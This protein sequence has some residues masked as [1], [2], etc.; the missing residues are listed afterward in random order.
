L[1]GVIEVKKGPDHSGAP[2]VLPPRLPL[3]GGDGNSM[4]FVLSSIV[5]AF[6]VHK[7]GFYMLAAI[8]S[9]ILWGIPTLFL[10]VVAARVR[11]DV[12][13]AICRFLSSIL[14]IGLAGVLAGGMARLTDADGRGGRA[15]IS[16]AFGFCASRFVPLFVG[17]ALF[18]IVIVVANVVTNGFVFLLNRGGT[19]GSF[20]A[21]FLFLPQFALNVGLAIAYAVSVLIPAAIAVEDTTALGAIGRLQ[22]C[23]CRDT[24]RLFVFFSCSVVGGLAIALVLVALLGPALLITLSTNSSFS[25]MF[26]ISALESQMESGRGLSHSPWPDRLRLFFGALAV[27]AL[28]GYLAAYWVGSFTGYYRDALRRGFH[29]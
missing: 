11:S 18:A 25:S 15:G 2:P 22:S 6:S 17:S 7:I 14:G 23:L 10:E 16:D 29:G 13:L 3:P 27:L 24:S 9:L 28:M 4:S 26:S 12:L 1:P 19:A 5:R 20:L 21:A 8:I